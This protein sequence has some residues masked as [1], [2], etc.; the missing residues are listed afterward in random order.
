V[1]AWVV[2]DVHATP[3]EIWGVLIDFNE[4]STRIPAVT[5]S[6]MYAIEA[7]PQQQQ[8]KLSTSTQGRNHRSRGGI[9]TTEGEERLWSYYAHFQ[10]KFLYWVSWDCFIRHT[11]IGFSTPND[12]ST[13]SSPRFIT[14]TLDPNRTMD[15]SPLKKCT[16]LWYVIPHPTKPGWSRVYFS[17][18]MHFQKWVPP[19][20][21]RLWKKK[22][23]SMATLWIPR[24]FAK[25]TTM[26]EGDGSLSLPSSQS[27]P[28]CNTLNGPLVSGSINH[29]AT[30]CPWSK[31]TTTSIREQ[32][33]SI[34][35]VRYILVV[36]VFLLTLA[37]LYLFLERM[38][39]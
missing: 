13:N 30:T 37:N 9:L 20:L 11:I 32:Q 16:G 17:I 26:K 18:Q 34:G 10:V 3:E 19:L 31:P 33:Q 23:I 6:E 25:T 7:P 36:M 24:Y 21:I 12:T 38:V 1:E 35:I 28:Y 8:P 39:T 15:T 4:Y 5:L 14:W 22:A 2:Q 27:P 29:V